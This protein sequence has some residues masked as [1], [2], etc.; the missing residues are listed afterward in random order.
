MMM[1]KAEETS[2][3]PNASSSSSSSSKRLQDDLG[4]N[5]GGSFA[6]PPQPQPPPAHV[7]L[8]RGGIGAAHIKLTSRND[9]RSEFD[10]S[11]VAS[12]EVNGIVYQGVLFAQN[13]H[14]L[15]R[16]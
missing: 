14:L 9:G 12:M 15:G 11:I 3:P 2:S 13:P 6:Q 5:N 16:I 7:L 4:A 10:A 8:G 1:M